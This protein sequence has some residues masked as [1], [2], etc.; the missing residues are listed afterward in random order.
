MSI[1]LLV[2][3]SSEDSTKDETVDED[4]QDSSLPTA[5]STKQ[6]TSHIPFTADEVLRSNGQERK[7]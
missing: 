3:F 2:P 7:V 4:V 6:G 5:P 1:H